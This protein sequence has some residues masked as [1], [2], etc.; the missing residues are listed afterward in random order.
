MS[1]QAGEH[2]STYPDSWDDLPGTRTAKPGHEHE[3]AKE[4]EYYLQDEAEPVKKGEHTRPDLNQPA[5][6]TP[7]YF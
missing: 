6:D 1:Q 5:K 3:N 4:Q 2:P 7:G